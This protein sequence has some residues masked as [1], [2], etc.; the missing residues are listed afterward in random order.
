MLIPMTDARQEFLIKAAEDTI[1]L[2]NVGVDPNA[3]LAKVAK[4]SELNSKEVALVSHAINNS[5]TIS[6]LTGSKPEDKEKPFTLTN[7]DVVNRNLYEAD[8]LTETAAKAKAKS[9]DKVEDEKAGQSLK[10]A[11]KKEAGARS[12]I[13][14]RSYHDVEPEDQTELLYRAF[15]RDTVLHI[16]QKVACSLEG[17]SLTPTL[18]VTKTHVP[19]GFTALYHQSECHLDKLSSIRIQIEEAGVIATRARDQVDTELTKLAHEMRRLDAPRFDRVEQC[20]RLNGCS[21]LALDLGF[22]MSKAA[23]FGHAR[24]TEI[25]TAGVMLFSPREYA[26]ATL[27]CDADRQI[28]VAT[29]AMAAKSILIEAHEDLRVK[30]EKLAAK[31][32]GGGDK[33]G[34]KGSGKGGDGVAGATSLVQDTGKQLTNLSTLGDMGDKLTGA[35]YFDSHKNTHDLLNSVTERSVGEKPMSYE[36]PDKSPFDVGFRQNLNNVDSRARIERLMQDDFV[37]HHPIQDVV[38]AYNRSLS[39]NPNLGDAELSG[40]VKQDLAAGGTVPL[41]TLLRT[42]ESQEPV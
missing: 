12:R 26:V 37:G 41:D 3:A 28:K 11:N 18:T 1:G 8:P 17:D 7:A 13:E 38:G 10:P 24:A 16:T 6:H 33:S 42:R 30:I 39:T 29:D 22:E 36:A 25:K 34:G 15:G 40:L 21:D 35:H 32:D 4:D 14:T 19:D 20:A 5:K 27:L 23:K 31:A 9:L 2:M